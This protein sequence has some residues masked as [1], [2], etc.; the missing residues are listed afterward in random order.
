MASED[1]LLMI[2]NTNE[3]NACQ[4]TLFSPGDSAITGRATISIGI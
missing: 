1:D 4:L 2:Y 3:S